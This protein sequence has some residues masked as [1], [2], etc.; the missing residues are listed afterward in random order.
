MGYYFNGDGH[1]DAYNKYNANPELRKVVEEAVRHI[2]A[3]AEKY[4]D[5]DKEYFEQYA[6]GVAVA[7][8][9]IFLDY[10]DYIF[11]PEIWEFNKKNV[12]YL[13]NESDEWESWRERT[14][15]DPPPHIKYAIDL[16]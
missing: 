15:E 4:D 3:L 1:Q 7:I 14:E 11:D 8:R 9:D 2:K 13:K 5:I 6:E 10:D 12:Y 16:R